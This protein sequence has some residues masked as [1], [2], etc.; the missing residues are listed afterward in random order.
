MKLLTRITRLSA[1]VLLVM[2]LAIPA[3]AQNYCNNPVPPCST[4]DPASPCY[5]PPDPPPKCE[6]RKCGKC[7]KSPCYAGSGVYAAEGH[8]LEITTTGFPIDVSRLYQ[9][10]HRIDG[11]SGVGRYDILRRAA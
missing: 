8:D 6:P 7:T 3:A 2:A 11:E 1:P 10:S 5:R 4:D 9:S